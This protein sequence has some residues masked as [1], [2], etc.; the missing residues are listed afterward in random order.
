MTG[1]SIHIRNSDVLEV[2]KK[3]QKISFEKTYF[4]FIFYAC[5]VRTAIPG[6]KVFVETSFDI[7]DIL[8]YSVLVRTEYGRN[9]CT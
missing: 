8:T 9:V 4:Y 6:N 5:P 7:N 3:T 2:R 1:I